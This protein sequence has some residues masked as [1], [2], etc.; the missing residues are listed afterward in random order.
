MRIKV[1]LASRPFADLRPTLQK[2]RISM[3]VLAGVAILL[4]IGLH[5]L[6]S[7]AAAARARENRIDSS[8]VG[9]NRE[10]LGYRAMMAQP[11]N[12][13]VLNE[14]EELNLLIDEKSFSWT[15]AMEDLERVLP[16]GVQ[17]TTLEPNRDKKTGE[18][19]VRLRV[20]GPRDKAVELVH[21][22][23]H[24]R[25][26]LQ[27]RIVAETAESAAGNAA[28]QQIEPVSASSRVNFDVVANYNPVTSLDRQ[29]QESKKSEKASDEQDVD[30]TPRTTR[31]SLSG[32][33]RPVRQSHQPGGAR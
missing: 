31:A 24:S 8:L 32:V 22:L 4:G 14:S 17:V 12:A 5:L 23:E 25:H 9:L 16:A 11:D 21:N 19:S 13:T 2:L 18:I 33:T 7:S 30:G 20:V 28:N 15:L 3:G 27:P 6:G 1:N 29:E 10:Q 26:F